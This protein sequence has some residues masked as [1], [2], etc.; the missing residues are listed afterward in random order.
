MACLKEAYNYGRY[1]LSKKK[2]KKK[3]GVG[4]LPPETK[5]QINCLYW[6]FL[7]MWKYVGK[8]S[9]AMKESE[10]SLPLDLGLKILQNFFSMTT[11][12]RTLD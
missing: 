8:N 12:N 1:K 11:D 2:K 3:G 9:T 7:L 6:Y 5:P 10:F 4:P